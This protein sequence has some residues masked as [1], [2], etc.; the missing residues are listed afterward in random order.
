MLLVDG[1]IID[2]VVVVD[3]SGYGVCLGCDGYGN[4]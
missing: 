3:G 1:I 4:L 2:W